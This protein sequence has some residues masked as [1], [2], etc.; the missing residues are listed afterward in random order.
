MNVTDSSD[1]AYFYQGIAQIFA[2]IVE[3]ASGTVLKDT[4]T[5]LTNPSLPNDYTRLA[6]FIASKR[7]S[8]VGNYKDF[9]TAYANINASGDCKY[10][11][12]RFRRKLSVV[13]QILQTA[14]GCTRVATNSDTINRLARRTN[15]SGMDFRLII[16]TRCARTCL[17]R[18]SV[19]RASTRPSRRQ[20]RITRDRR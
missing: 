7:S 10:F 13:N 9:V 17:A 3:Y 5:L 12:S 18:S 11:K 15:R 6:N 20:T 16:F 14:S 2:R 8:C 19:N 1:K 4:C